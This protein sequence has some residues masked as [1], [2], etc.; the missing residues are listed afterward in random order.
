MA[1]ELGIAR[2]KV[3]APH[4]R[5][6]APYVATAQVAFLEH[7]DI[8]H[9]VVFGEVI[10]RAQPMAAAADDHRVIFRLRLWIAPMRCPTA[11]AGQTFA[12]HA[13]S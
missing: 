2:Q 10:G 12:Q 13:Q 5:R 3:I 9:A 7:R 4:D 1:V 6:V 11:I 8:R